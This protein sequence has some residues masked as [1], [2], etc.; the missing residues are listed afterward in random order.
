MLAGQNI[1]ALNTQVPPAPK[2]ALPT[3]TFSEEETIYLNGVEVHL[4]RVAPAHTD[5]D[6]LVHFRELNVLH[7]GDLLFNGFYPFID[8]SSK[9]WLGGMITAANTILKEVN[10]GT[11]I[12]PGH[13]PM[14]TMKQVQAYRD[15]LSQVQER[16][17]PLVRAGKPTAE[18]VAEKPTKDLDE[19]WGKGFLKP[20]QFVTIV[21]GCIN[22]PQV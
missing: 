16:I 4:R 22:P 8:A 12:I 2:P 5:G 19:T 6:T 11:Q 14:A 18:I 7:T 1:A 10:A 20:E 13:G 9:G 21:C 3:V 17:E 15:M